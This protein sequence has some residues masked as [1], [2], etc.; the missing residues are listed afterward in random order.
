MGLKNTIQNTIQKEIK[1]PVIR[2][3]VNH[4]PIPEGYSFSEYVN[5]RFNLIPRD[6]ERTF[7]KPCDSKGA[8]VP[9]EPLNRGLLN[10]SEGQELQPAGL[11]SSLDTNSSKTRTDDT[12]LISKLYGVLPGSVNIPELLDTVQKTFNDRDADSKS[13]SIPFL[14]AAELLKESPGNLYALQ[15]L[16]YW[17]AIKALH[18]DDIE[19]SKKKCMIFKRIG[20]NHFRIGPYTTRF[21]DKDYRKNQYK[22]L[23]NIFAVTAKEHKHAVFLTLTLAP[24]S[25]LNLYDLN[26]AARSAAMKLIRYYLKRLDKSGIPSSYV[27]VPEY[28]KNGRIHFHTVI[29]GPS[30]LDD[31]KKINKLAK[32]VG[33]GYSDVVSLHSDNGYWH[34][35]GETHDSSKY[36]SYYLRKSIT[37]PII[38]CL[39]WANNQ[40]FFSNSEVFNHTEYDTCNILKTLFNDK[41]YRYLGTYQISTV[42]QVFDSMYRFRTPADLSG[43]GVEP[44]DSDRAIVSEITIELI[45]YNEQLAEIFPLA[46]D[47]R[48]DPLTIIGEELLFFTGDHYL[49]IPLEAA[50]ALCQAIENNEE[51]ANAIGVIPNA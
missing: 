47:N 31:I 50:K 12:T 30:R 26:K 2:D 33:L 17:N 9:G 32:S 22:K 45:E 1:P 6:T 23:E 25:E 28:Q 13:R 48:P 51:F 20:F 39:Y 10:R 37:D 41:D 27:M 11:E 24:S 15:F 42:K 8:R 14:I 21:T 43:W 44:P 18:N 40:K 34:R 38:A 4:P 49:K 35:K 3:T 19:N 36:L 7:L 16:P 29:F 46:K 5:E